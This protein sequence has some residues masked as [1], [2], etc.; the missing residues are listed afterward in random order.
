MCFISTLAG[1][2]SFGTGYC[3]QLFTGIY[4]AQGSLLDTQGLHR[5]PR[6][7]QA[8]FQETEYPSEKNINTTRQG[9]LIFKGTLDSRCWWS[10]EEKDVFCWLTREGSLERMHLMSLDYGQHLG[11]KDRGEKTFRRGTT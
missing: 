1:E 7:Q 9:V 4:F 5:S 3:N 11:G 8:P 6:Q 10:S 2:Q